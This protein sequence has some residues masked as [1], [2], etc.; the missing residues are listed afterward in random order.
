MLI[1][2]QSNS[3][4]ISGD[5]NQLHLDPDVYVGGGPSLSGKAGMYTK[6]LI[7]SKEQTET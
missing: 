1:D 2:E 4:Q 3:H 5:N 7:L 6:Q